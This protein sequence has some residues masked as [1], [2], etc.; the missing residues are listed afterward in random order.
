MITFNEALETIQKSK[1][2]VGWL[3]GVKTC[4]KCNSQT[5]KDES[6]DYG[7]CECH[8]REKKALGTWKFTPNEPDYNDDQ[9]SSKQKIDPDKKQDDDKLKKMFGKQALGKR[10]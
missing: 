7:D 9:K 4:P 2:P 10:K 3:R 6:G 8:Y 1:M 5:G